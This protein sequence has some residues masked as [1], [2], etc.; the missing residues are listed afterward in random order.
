[1]FDYSFK[2]GKIIGLLKV[3]RYLALTFLKL[4]SIGHLEGVRYLGL[5]YL[6]LNVIYNC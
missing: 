1:L 6:K 3:G 2:V 5:A 4:K